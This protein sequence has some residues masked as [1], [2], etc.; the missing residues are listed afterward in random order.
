[1][2]LRLGQATRPSP[3]TCVIRRCRLPGPRHVH[4]GATSSG[5]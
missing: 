2:D 4:P 5:D 1:L 3:I